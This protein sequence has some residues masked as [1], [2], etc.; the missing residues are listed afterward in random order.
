MNELNMSAAEAAEHSI[1]GLKHFV[2]TVATQ[3][4]F[5]RNTIGYWATG[6]MV[7]KCLINIIRANVFTN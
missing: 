6:T 3:L 5:E 1:H 4:N 2:V 7:Q